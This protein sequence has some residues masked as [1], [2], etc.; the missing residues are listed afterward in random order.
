MINFPANDPPA[1]RYLNTLA[2]PPCDVHRWYLPG[3]RILVGG[4]VV[5]SADWNHLVNDFGITH[6]L[7]L[8]ARGREFIPGDRLIAVDVPD[9]GLPLAAALLREAC[10][11]AREVLLRNG[12]KLYVHDLMGAARGSAFA[13]AIL[14]GVLE[15]SHEEAIVAV[16]QGVPHSSGYHWGY[17]DAARAHIGSVDLWIDEGGLGA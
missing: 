12:E 2:A 14:R 6:C 15:K 4:S 11:R 1:E 16:N 7:S 5:S 10:G 17:N 9:S 3:H 8:D 13:Y